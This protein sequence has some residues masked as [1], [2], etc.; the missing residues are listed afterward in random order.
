MR[1]PLKYGIFFVILIGIG[2]TFIIFYNTTHQQIKESEKD[3][4][5]RKKLDAILKS[6]NF[7]WGPSYDTD[8]KQ[9]LSSS[10]TATTDAEQQQQQQLPPQQLRCKN[11]VQGIDYVTD[12][13]GYLCSRQYIDLV[14]G[15]CNQTILQQHSESFQ[16]GSSSQDDKNNNNNHNNN[17]LPIKQKDTD[18]IYLKYQDPKEK[19]FE[20]FT[21]TRCKESMGCCKEYE[22]CVSCCMRSDKIPTLRDTFFS[23]LEKN[24]SSFIKSQFDLCSVA[25]RTSSNS[26]HNQ[27]EYKQQEYK[28]CYGPS[29]PN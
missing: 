10:G 27:R 18:S 14:T 24:Y 1:I 13:Q 28:F 25:C 20:R 3:I 5:Q 2:F 15:C 22:F 17:K 12:S 29:T 6:V 21:C 26:L 19:I 23:I 8:N 7:R 9:S 11:T 16:S 4:I